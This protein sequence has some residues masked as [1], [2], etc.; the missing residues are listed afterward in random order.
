[1]RAPL[2]WIRDFTPVDAPVADLVSALNQLGLEV[3]GVEQPGAEIT[4][5]IAARVLERREAPRRRQAVAGRRDHR[6]GRD[7]RRVRRAQRGRRHGGALRAVGRDAA[8]RLHPRAAQDP[9]PGER[10]HAVLGEGARPRRRPLGHPRPRPRRRAG[11]R[12]ARAA[13]PRRR[14]LRPRDHPQPARRDV[15]RAA[16]PASS[17]RTSRS[18]S[19]CPSRRWRRIPPSPATSAS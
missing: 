14:H 3:E 10:R 1:M 13:R 6:R 8:R 15:H 16:S 17:P 9:R 19:T 12:R 5:V 4:G 11:R 2:S 7:P 18:T